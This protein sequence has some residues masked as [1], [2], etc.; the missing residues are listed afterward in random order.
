[1]ISIRTEE[2][3]VDLRQRAQALAVTAAWAKLG[4]FDVL[5]DGGLHTLTELEGEPRAL[6]ISA[7]VLAHAGVLVGDGERWALSAAGRALASAQPRKSNA[8]FAIKIE[9]SPGGEKTKRTGRDEKRTSGHRRSIGK[10]KDIQ[11]SPRPGH[12]PPRQKKLAQY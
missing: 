8:D 2:D 5:A 7:S 4:F 11:L 6:D 1:M 9:T 12:R 3:L 10:N